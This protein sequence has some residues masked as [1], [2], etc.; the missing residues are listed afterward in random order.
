MAS[1]RNSPPADDAAPTEVATSVESAVRE[2][3]VPGS[4]LSVALSGGIDSMVLLDAL[5]RLSAAHPFE[6]RAI[7]VNHGLSP[8]AEDWSVFCAAQCAA[9]GV[10]L[11]IQR[12]TLE[13]KT[14]SL[15][16]KSRAERYARLNAS[17]ADVV[18]LAHHAD[19][20]AET[21]LLQM[22]RGAGPR[23]LSAMPRFRPGNPAWLRP[24]LGSRRATLC[25]Y[26]KSRGLAWIDDESNR[27]PRHKRNLLRHQIVPLL[28]THFP[29]YPETMLRVAELQAEANGLVDALAM[30]DAAGACDAMG[31]DLA[32][33]NSLSPSRARNLMRWF[34]QREGLRPPSQSRL[35]EMLRQLNHALPDS[36]MRFA[37]DGVEIGCH[38]DR[39]AVHAAPRGPFCLVWNGEPEVTLPG[40]VV[41]FRDARGAGVSVQKLAR[42]RVTLRS[43]V[44]G[45]RIQIASNRPRRALKRWLQEASVPP[46]NRAMV[47][48]VWCGDE[49]AAVPGIGVAAAF[50]TAPEEPGWCVDW[51]PEGS[52]QVSG[53]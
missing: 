34:L 43:R 13:R 22:L 18:A 48:L 46:W 45:E 7:H 1:T 2:F 36:R 52:Q 53:T 29:G 49:L 17:G 21:V 9:R 19:D 5:S 35:A 41:M 50:Q 40:G 32:R 26:A 8:H 42:A 39:I 31:L 12:L 37:H 3:V 28:R 20:Q 15:E 4:R 27:E 6:L 23:G 11:D 38:H 33:L 51:L 14:A 44:G 16:A 10:P 30:Q 25:A 24:L 47:P